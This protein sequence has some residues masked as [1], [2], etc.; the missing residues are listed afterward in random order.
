MFCPD[1]FFLFLDV[2]LGWRAMSRNKTI[3]VWRLGGVWLVMQ[4]REWFSG[5]E[6]VPLE[7]FYRYKGIL[8]QCFVPVKRFKRNKSSG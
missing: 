7:T 2:A 8:L 6:N 4:L 1:S 3:P 5:C